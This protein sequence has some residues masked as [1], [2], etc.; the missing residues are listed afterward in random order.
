MT[1]EFNPSPRLA[2]RL[3]E[4]IDA[5]RGWNRVTKAK[6][7]YQIKSLGLQDRVRLANRVKLIKSIKGYTNAPNLELQR[8]AFSFT[9][10]GIFM[11]RGVGLGRKA[12]SAEAKAQLQ[13]EKKQI[14]LEPVLPDAIEELADLLSNKYADMAVDEIRLLIPGIIDTK[15]ES[16]G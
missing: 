15:V 2:D 4:A 13:K 11:E 12:G 1:D 6:L 7:K 5:T 3:Q 14:W 9:K 8:V 16:N 10:H